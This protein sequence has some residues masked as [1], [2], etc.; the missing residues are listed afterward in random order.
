MRLNTSI[1]ASTAKGNIKMGLPC[2]NQPR[3]VKAHGSVSTPLGSTTSKANSSLPVSGLPT[4]S[5][6]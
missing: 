1:A 6:P 5:S 2:K 4:C 3:R